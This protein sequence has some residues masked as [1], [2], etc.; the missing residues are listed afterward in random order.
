MAIVHFIFQKKGGA[1]KSLIFT[2][3]FQYLDE[4]GQKVFGI[5][6]D[7]SNH[8]FAGFTELGI[9]ELN[10][11]NKDK[12]IDQRMFDPLIETIFELG[13]ND[14]LVVDSGSSCFV[15]LMAYL[16]GSN[17]FEIILEAGHRIYIHVPVTGGS[18][19]IHTAACLD[20]LVQA[21]PELP[22]IVW[23][24]QY[25]GELAMD[26]KEFEEFKIYKKHSARTLRD[27]W[28]ESTLL[29][30]LSIPVSRLWFGSG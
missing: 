9:T 3:W 5:D 22:F 8:T 29:K 30:R 19:M 6:T 18:D 21:F 11:M 12:D 17:A 15:S 14:H 24:N 25:H 1:G 28:S 10:I 2:M 26:G 16:Q 4:M 23:K 7:P 27:Y 20:E 13:E